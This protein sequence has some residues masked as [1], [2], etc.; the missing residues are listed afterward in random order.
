MATSFGAAAGAY[1][2]G[3]PT[4]PADAV[5]WLFEGT[6]APIVDIVDVGAGTGKL[7]RALLG[8]GRRLTAI[9]PDP[10]ML[11]V[12]AAASPDVVTAVGTAESLPLADDSADLVTLGQA[13][14]WVDP[15]AGSAEIGRV[16]RPGG[17]L[18]LLWNV[19][20]DS[21]P[22][23]A[24]MSA[25]MHHSA[26]ERIIHDDAV[27]VGA[28]FGPLEERTWSWTRAI[29]RSALL[30]MVASRSYVIT[31]DATTRERIDAQLAELFDSLPEL[32]DGGT[33][34]LPYTTH[35][36]RAVAQRAD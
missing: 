34:D 27:A 28:P 33:V 13:W 1:D 5:A 2:V 14:H 26:G 21:V 24:A 36:F 3:R 31:A 16:L 18:G 10:E 8:E 29:D 7:T 35:V 17:T 11:A 6:D 4:Y 22:W 25:I 9:D 12:L 30:D 15:A 32:A 23:V 19:R 20:D